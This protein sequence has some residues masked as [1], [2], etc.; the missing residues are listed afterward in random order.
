MVFFAVL[1]DIL[2]P[3]GI[4]KIVNSLCACLNCLFA[5]RPPGLASSVGDLSN[6]RY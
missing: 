3:R 6:C 1:K 4:S 2:R 5:Q